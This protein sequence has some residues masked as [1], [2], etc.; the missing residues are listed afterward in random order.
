[1]SYSNSYQSYVGIVPSLDAGFRNLT[2]NNAII[3]N[4]I[5][6]ERDNEI[7]IGRPSKRFRSAYIEEIEGV[8][9]INGI[10]SMHMITEGLVHKVKNTID[11]TTHIGVGSPVS[12]ISAQ[13]GAVVLLPS[14][15]LVATGYDNT[16]FVCF[17]ATAP[18]DGTWTKIA[19]TV[20][21]AAGYTHGIL[22]YNPTTDTLLSMNTANV[23]S[24]YISCPAS[25]LSAW[26]LNF[27]PSTFSTAVKCCVVANG[28]FVALTDT[29]VYISS[30]GLTSSWTDIA[31]YSTGT[32][33]SIVV[34]D[35]MERPDWVEGEIDRYLLCTTGQGTIANVWYSTT[36]NESTVWQPYSKALGGTANI[37]MFLYNPYYRTMVLVKVN[38]GGHTFDYAPNTIGGLTNEV[39][40]SAQFPSSNATVLLPGQQNN[41][42]PT[43]RS[44]IIVGM[45]GPT[46]RQNN[47]YIWT[48]ERTTTNIQYVSGSPTFST[49]TNSFKSFHSRYSVDTNANVAYAAIL[50][51]GSINSVTNVEREAFKIGRIHLSFPDLSLPGGST[52]N[53]FQIPTCSN[54]IKFDRYDRLVSLSSDNVSGGIGSA[55][56]PIK[57]VNYTSKLKT[58]GTSAAFEFRGRGKSNVIDNV[59]SSI[60]TEPIARSRNRCFP[61]KSHVWTSVSPTAFAAATRHLCTYI[62]ELKRIYAIGATI[63]ALTPN[64]VSFSDDGG[65]SWTAVG[66]IPGPSAPGLTIYSY[67]EFAY[68]PVYG[69]LVVCGNNPSSTGFPAFY[70]SDLGATWTMSTA[71]YQSVQN[72]SFGHVRWVEEYGESGLFI[73]MATSS[74]TTHI[75]NQKIM[76]S[77]DGKSWQN[78]PSVAGTLGT[79]NSISMPQVCGHAYDQSTKTMC[80]AARNLTPSFST[81]VFYTRDGY[82]WLSSN[83]H[84]LNIRT[85]PFIKNYTTLPANSHINFK[86]NGGAELTAIL[87]VGTW[88]VSELAAD[89]AAKMTAAAGATITCSFSS[90]TGFFT[91]AHATNPLVLLFG[92]GTN[93]TTSAFRELGFAEA[94]LGPLTSHVSSVKQYLDMG[95]FPHIAYSPPLD[96]WVM[97]S[98]SN[99]NNAALNTSSNIYWSADPVN[100]FWYRAP[101]YF[102]V[103]LPNPRPNFSDIIWCENLQ[104]F[105]LLNQYADFVGAD[106]KDRAIWLSRD[107]MNFESSE[108]STGPRTIVSFGDMSMKKITYDP[109][110]NTM[111]I[112]DYDS[113]DSTII[114]SYSFA[115]I[116]RMG[117]ATLPSIR[118]GTYTHPVVFPA[119]VTT[120]TMPIDPPLSVAPNVAN[121]IVTKKCA[122]G[123]T[124]NLTNFYVQSVSTTAITVFS[125]STNLNNDLSTFSWLLWESP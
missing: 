46:S 116:N 79:Q 104:M 75:L 58:Q 109:I 35:F 93:K 70:S 62:P 15:T 8:S 120:F 45:E 118:I 29:N 94:D 42:F 64:Q 33:S 31:T 80:V 14:G 52:L 9:L 4:G 102:Q 73:M 96:I 98:A 76:I 90:G 72:A 13:L 59:N 101:T 12:V 78:A 25:D 36:L 77:T 6:P 24:T 108:N 10:D 86:Y 91:I 115:T 74:S 40:N 83:T 32:K 82:N 11:V 119:G 17:T 49:T 3:R 97:A 110:F 123:S 23:T 121:I 100:G 95:I 34:R 5:E 55:H 1:M 63:I 20:P 18:G 85:I 54:R 57:S 43:L 56:Y 66:S 71:P 47:A 26:Q 103:G 50:M 30:T 60:I 41:Y 69:T 107:G 88:S 38:D 22:V 67:A 114:T 44:H 81:S 21:L 65:T 16:E 105:V 51:F 125:N 117:V 84:K 89:V 7:D 113:A 53:T 87:N 28:Y 111:I 124:T 99:S 19:N 61:M 122:T 48:G 2:V 39:Q 68:S 112:S 37:K 27:L 106:T 92:T